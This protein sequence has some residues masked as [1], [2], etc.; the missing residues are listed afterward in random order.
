MTIERTYDPVI[1][2]QKLRDHLSSH[3]KPIAL[4]FGA[5]TSCAVRATDDQ[6]LIPAVAALTK[7]CAEAVA[8]LED[9]P[10]KGAWDLIA[11]SLP[12]GRRDVEEMLS[13][14]RR[15]LEA[16]LEGDTSAG[17]DHGQL[18]EMEKTIKGTIA[19]EVTPDAS[20]FP[21]ELPHEAIG[22][23][24]RSIG[25]ETPIEIFSLNYDTLIE[26]GLEAEW[27]PYFDGF[28]GSHRPFFSAGSLVRPDMLPGR[29]WARLWKL[30]G[31]VTWSQSGSGDRRRVIRGPESESGEMIL[32]SLRKYEESRKQPYVAMLDRLRGVLTER[33]DIVLITLGYSFS[34]Q[35]INE[36]LFEALDANP[37]LHVFAL[38]FEDPPVDGVLHGEALAQRKLL[39]F[40]PQGGVIGGI[41]GTWSVTDPK[42][43][44]ARLADVFVLNGEAGPGGKLTL[45]DFN[46]FSKL[47]DALAEQSADD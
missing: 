45:G 34:D 42:G 31:S 36:V 12:D 28:V 3:D 39:V 6:P 20:R 37:G 16:I 44:G 11:D 1:E 18:E 15:K 9:G 29:R 21:D 2:V 24:L 17:L 26:R 43:S 13:S 38:C 10:F 4:L 32:P 33:D 5:G 22:R 41:P 25:R 19:A 8:E 7:R 47:L 40:S 35:H 14:V 27:V 46:S 23:W 30:H